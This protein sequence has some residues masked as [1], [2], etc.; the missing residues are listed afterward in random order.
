MEQRREPKYSLAPFTQVREENFG[1][2]FYTM[3]G[4][5]LFFLSS[6][7]ML[8][9]HFFQGD[10]TL[11]QWMEQQPAQGIVSKSRIADLKKALNQLKEKGV[12]LEC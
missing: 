6:G 12:V 7:K 11:K 4:P 3:S 2:L 1:L 8:K 9:S 10:L 5:R